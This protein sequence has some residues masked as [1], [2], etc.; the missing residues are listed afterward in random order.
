[1]LADNPKIG[2]GGRSIYYQYS[3]YSPCVF[4]GDKGCTLDI[5]TR[6]EYCLAIKPKTGDK[7]CEFDFK[8][9]DKLHVARAWKRTGIDLWQWI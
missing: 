2:Y 1:M 4:L 3:T 7:G 6:P 8:I 5:D 9:H